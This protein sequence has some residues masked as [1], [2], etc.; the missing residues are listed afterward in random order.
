MIIRDLIGQTDPEKEA[1]IKR[2]TAD[3]AFFCQ[4]Y[5]P[6]AFYHP[7]A[8][9]QKILVEII[10][11]SAVTEEHIKRLKKFI[12]PKHHIYLRP[13]SHLDGLLDFE[14]RDHGKTTRMSQFFPLWLALTRKRVFPLTI[15]VSTERAAEWLESIKFELE[16]N[17]RLIEDF[18]EQKS[19]IWRKNKIVLKNGNAV[20][21][22][23]K[24]EGIRGIK[25]KT[26]RPTHIICDDLLKDDEVDSKT[27]RDKLYRWFKRV[28]MNLG[29][30]ALIVMVNTI[31]HPDDLPS[32]LL[33]TIKESKGKK[34]KNWVAFLFSAFT[35]EGEPLWPERW[36]KETLLQKKEDLDPEIWATE[37]DN[38]PQ[39]ESEKKFRREWFKF[40][41]LEDVD[42]SNLRKVM[43]IDPA[44]GKEAGDYS[45]VVVTGLAPNGLIYTLD[46]WGKKISD[47]DLIAKIISMFKIWRPSVI[48]FEIN[49]FQEIYKNMLLREAMREGLI[50]PVIG[51]K[52]TGN[53][54]F[55]ISKLSPLVEAGILRFRPE[56]SLLLEQL[57]FF[58]KT[59]DDLP[60]ALE[61]AVSVLINEKSGPVEYETVARRR[62]K[63]GGTW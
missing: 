13:V 4:Y 55:R 19:K 42:L 12:K 47:L 58:P 39:P 51:Q 45:A 16:N 20:A 44:T 35:P 27:A 33:K 32:R 38:E 37:W 29:K 54:Q 62:Y 21:T 31:M 17:D 7:L 6:D 26:R 5:F 25:D 57:E 23:G 3:F 59:H 14:P 8:E 11:Q 53:K 15:G 50:L 1:R 9:Y 24:G 2:A 52:Q 46:A 63:R 34:L 41:E 43:A 56:Q 28:V 10:N 18:G 61:M 36:D 60:D 49:V 40:F 48:L 30:G 22:L